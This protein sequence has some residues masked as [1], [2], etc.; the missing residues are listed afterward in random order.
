[1]LYQ[2]IISWDDM[3]DMISLRAARELV[4]LGSAREATLK[5]RQGGYAVVL[6][7]GLEERSISTKHGALR[8]FPGIA[9]AARFLRM[10]GIQHYWV[11]A[12]GFVEKRRT[13][14]DRAAAMQRVHASH[15]MVRK[16]VALG[17]AGRQD[18][19][20]H[21]AEDVEAEALRLLAGFAD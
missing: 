18:P 1:M 3:A 21:R 2:A 13:R 19:V 14:A 20:R 17:E 15:A 6:K 9:A 11:D 16:L 10:L 12:S 4:V 8:V 5:G 7:V